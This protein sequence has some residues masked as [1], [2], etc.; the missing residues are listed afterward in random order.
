MQ[1]RIAIDFSRLYLYEAKLSDLFAQVNC[2]LFFRE[3]TPLHLSAQYG[4]LDISRLLLRC[5][6]DVD[7]KDYV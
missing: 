4:H 2:L 7:A 1:R 6:V 3:R 5:K